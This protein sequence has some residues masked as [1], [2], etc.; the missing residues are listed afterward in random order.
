MQHGA[1]ERSGLDGKRGVPPVQ[2]ARRGNGDAS[3]RATR[4]SFFVPLSRARSVAGVPGPLGRL[5]GSASPSRRASRRASRQCLRPLDARPPTPPSAQ[6]LEREEAVVL[7]ATEIAR[8]PVLSAGQAGGAADACPVPRRAWSVCGPGCGSLAPSAIGAHGAS[9]S[10]SE[11]HG[12]HTSSGV[13]H[14]AGA[15]PYRSSH[16]GSL[17]PVEG[18]RTATLPCCDA[19]PP[20]PPAPD[21]MVSCACIAR[22]V[23]PA[24]RPG[25]RRGILRAG[26]LGPEL[27]EVQRRQRTQGEAAAGA[28]WAILPTP[29]KPG[30][31]GGGN[32]GWLELT[33][34]LAPVAGGRWVVDLASRDL[35]RSR[36]LSQAAGEA[37]GRVMSD[38]LSHLACVGWPIRSRRT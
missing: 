19:V 28:I 22:C 36:A 5:L 2:R 15:Y 37:C 8:P 10:H 30:T 27:A 34:G 23:R 21:A 3:A 9:R 25:A 38:G 17:R 33:S 20:L 29:D 26:V 7:K 1:E 24:P 32:D 6:L 16:C 14:D 35:A 31:P 12:L 4:M 18:T 11:T 13:S